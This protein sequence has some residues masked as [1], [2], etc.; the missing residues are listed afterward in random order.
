MDSLKLKIAKN[1]KILASYIQE[2]A[3][4]RNNALGNDMTYEAIIDLKSNHFQLVRI[5]WQGHKFLYAVL[6]HFDINA[7]TGN[8]WVQQNNT[9]ILLDDELA[10]LGIPKN[11][12][13]LDFRPASM[14]LFSDFAVA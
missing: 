6:I 3:D 7:E 8:I 2:L 4:E 9:E 5:G 12:L 11:N 10:M 13:V 1:K 14:R